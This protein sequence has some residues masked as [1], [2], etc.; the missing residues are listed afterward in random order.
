VLLR[1]REYMERAKA[2]RDNVTASLT[3]PDS[4]R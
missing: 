4:W 3:Y 2:L 1:L